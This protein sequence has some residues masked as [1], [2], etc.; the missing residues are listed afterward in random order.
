MTEAN[1]EARLQYN[2]VGTGAANTITTGALDD[3]IDGGG[4]ND[5]LNGGDGNDTLNGGAGDDTMNGGAGNDTFRFQSSADADGDTILDFQ[6]G[7]KIDL[8]AID[9]N[10]GSIGNGTFTLVTGDGFN[11]AGALRVGHET[12]DDGDYTVVEGNTDGD[13]DADFQISIRGNHNLTNTDFNL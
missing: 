3:T 6:P 7:D 4:G 5:I 13:T 8:S 2:L 9:A 11:A 12:R 1:F 10:S